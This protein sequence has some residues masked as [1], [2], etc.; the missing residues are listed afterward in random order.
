MLEGRKFVVSSSEQ[1][2][3]DLKILEVSDKNKVKVI[4]SVAEDLSDQVNGWNVLAQNPITNE[5]FAS[6]S[7]NFVKKDMETEDKQLSSVQIWNL[8]EESLSNFSA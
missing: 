1:P 3:P 8:S 6:A 7:T 4:A 2:Y 5:I